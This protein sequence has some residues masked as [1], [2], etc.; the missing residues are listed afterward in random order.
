MCTKRKKLNTGIKHPTYIKQFVTVL[1]CNTILV[2][3][4]HSEY[5]IPWDAEIIHSC[6]AVNCMHLTSTCIVSS[7]LCYRSKYHNNPCYY[8]QQ[9]LDTVHIFTTNWETSEN[10]ITFSKEAEGFLWK[11][12]GLYEHKFLKHCIALLTNLQKYCVFHSKHSN[13]NGFH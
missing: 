4:V 9:S 5:V 2:H 7:A 6:N 3:H 8:M 1:F 10:R 12:L 11:A 13:G